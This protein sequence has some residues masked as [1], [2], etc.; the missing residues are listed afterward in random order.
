[1]YSVAAIRLLADA[2]G[3]DVEIAREAE[4]SLRGAAVHALSQMGIEVDQKSASKMIKC[5]RA[6]AAKHRRR[7]QRQIDLEAMLTSAR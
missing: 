3:R 2:I 5:N 7:R 1:V 6:L 4:A